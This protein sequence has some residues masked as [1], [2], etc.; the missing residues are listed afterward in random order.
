MMR[1][2]LLTKIRPDLAAQLDPSQR[3]AALLEAA[4]RFSKDNNNSGRIILDAAFLDASGGMAVVE[5]EDDND[6]KDW[7]NGIPVNNFTNTEVLP[8]VDV[9]KA[10]DDQ[11]RLLEP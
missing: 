10:I 6:L 3:S 5:A 8:L 2:L 4:W 11:K 1:Y 7:M 9:K